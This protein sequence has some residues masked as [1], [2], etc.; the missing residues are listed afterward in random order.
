MKCNRICRLLALAVILSLLVIA[1]PA[2][3]VLAAESIELSPTTAEVGDEIDIDGDGFKTDK[4]KVYIYFSNHEGAVY[5]RI[6]DDVTVYKLAKKTTPN[7]SGR[8]DTSFDVPEVL[9]E[10][11]DKD[12]LD[13]EEVVGG[14]YYVYVTYGDSDKI[15]AVAVFTVR[16]IELNPASGVAGDSVE[17]SGVGFGDELSVS[18]T[19]N[20]VDVFTSPPSIKTDGAG[21]F[22]A[23]FSVPNVAAA[24]YDI[25][26]EDEDGND[27]EAEF[28]V[29][30]TPGV[31]L[32]PVTTQAAPAYVGMNIAISGIGFKANSSIT[33]TDT[34]SGLLLAVTNTSINGIF[35]SFF[36]ASGRAGQH[37]VTASDSTDTRQVSFIMES[38][39]PPKPALLLPEDNTETEAQAYFDWGDVSDDSLPVTYALQLASS[40]N[41]TPSSIVLEKTGL[42]SSE[43]TVTQGEK[44]APTEEAPYYW[45]VRAVDGASND[46]DWSAAGLF[47]VAESSG[48]GLPA[49]PEQFSR[50]GWL[51]YLWI[52]L[53][54]VGAVS[55]GYWLRRRIT[56]SR[57]V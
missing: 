55:L 1:I 24:T 43:Y 36:E 8:I 25:K 50:P 15:E 34:T 51:I 22:T 44:L 33:I 56:H 48:P 14:N 37:T 27:M 28:T 6:D 26:V 17:V 57:R 49:Q 20:G 9:D 41:F 2:S 30:V 19:F 31:S 32:S 16:G 35:Q 21:N 29:E 13:P 10:G 45:R 38:Q 42:T 12:Y 40:E 53:G 5:D 18:I 23:S 39:A 4:T 11:V 46:G 54:I 7:T 3:P 47:Y 52:G